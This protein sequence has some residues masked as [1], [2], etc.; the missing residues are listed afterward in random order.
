M[1][2][3]RRAV[4]GA[5]IAMVAASLCAGPRAAADQPAADPGCAWQAE[6]SP[7]TVA[8]VN[9]A[10]PDTGA[11]Y[12]ILPYQV[13]PGMTITAT[14]QYPDSRYISFNTYDARF[15]S[16]SN[17]GVSSALPDYLIAPD[18]GS[19]NPWQRPGGGTYTVTIGSDRTAAN[20]LPLAPE[21]ESAG[22]G[23]LIYREY[24]PSGGASSV[25]LPRIRIT[26]DTGSRTLGGCVGGGSPLLASALSALGATA[27]NL[28]PA[29]ADNLEFRRVSGAGAFP[30]ADNA[31]LVATLTPPGDD[32]VV[33]VRGKAPVAPA[34]TGPMVWPPGASADVRYFSLCANLSTLPGP[35]VLNPAADG[36]T[37][38]GCRS[39]RETLLDADRDYTYVLGTEAQRARI[40]AMPGA[41][42]VPLSSAHPTTQEA[43]LLRNMLPAS[44]FRQAVQS[45]PVNG[46]PAQAAEI[47]G[48][49]YPRATMCPLAAVL[50]RTC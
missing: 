22:V 41:T 49:Y 25:R 40:E 50:D 1:T 39:D 11:W 47:M 8:Q 31:Y 15:S 21:G 37:D 32:K 27:A 9:F 46:T 30:N 10:Y 17:G 12:W 48:P 28:P 45:V 18:A 35:V 38:N 23:F 36:S 7:R 3:L 19:V 26:D 33:V 34:G 44:D 20:A 2:R 5:I 24:L 42:F 16:F 13:R 14:G 29:T 43:I 4:P 6:L